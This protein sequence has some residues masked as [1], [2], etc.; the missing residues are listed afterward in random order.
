V[1]EIGNT[2]EKFPPSVGQIRTRAI[3]L[4]HGD[5]TR[6]TGSEAWERVCQWNRET[7]PINAV[8]RRVSD[9]VLTELEKRALKQIGGTW[10]ID[11]TQSPDMLRAQFIKFYDQ[12]ISKTAV[13]RN[14]APWTKQLVD[15]TQLV[16][17][18]VE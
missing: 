14:L 16:K 11:H 2:S 6:P 5:V 1:E 9:I 7:G 8:P 15:N 13:E 18:L 12:Q 17:A 10:A 3:E 4:S